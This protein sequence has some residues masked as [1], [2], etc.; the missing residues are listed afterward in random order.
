MTNM[1]YEKQA[2]GTID[3]VV[4]KIPSSDAKAS[5]SKVRQSCVDSGERNIA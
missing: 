3:E 1:L 2:S 4:A 5:V